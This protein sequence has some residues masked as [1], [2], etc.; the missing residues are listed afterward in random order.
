MNTSGNDKFA[1]F[2]SEDGHDKPDQTQLIK[3]NFQRVFDAEVERFSSFLTFNNGQFLQKIISTEEF[4][5]KYK[6]DLPYLFKI[7]VI[8]LGIPC[9]SASIEPFFSMCGDMSKKQVHLARL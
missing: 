2:F 3:E 6:N 4:S 7:A 5:L 9:S 1:S 8:L